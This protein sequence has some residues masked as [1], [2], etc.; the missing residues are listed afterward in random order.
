MLTP[1]LPVC[2]LLNSTFRLIN[3]HKK[4]T[5]SCRWLTSNLDKSYEVTYLK[6]SHFD[7]SHVTILKMRT[8]VLPVYYSANSTFWL[9][10]DP[11]KRTP[12]YRWLKSNLDK[13]YEL[14][15]SNYENFDIS[16]VTISKMWIPVLPVCNSLNSVF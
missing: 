9:I 16:Q 11:K 7:I 1:A 14:T 6:Y 8:A 15:Y 12:L 2:Y 3:N 13:S 4:E 10:N 5:S